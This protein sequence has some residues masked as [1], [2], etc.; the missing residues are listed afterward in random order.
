MYEYVTD[1]NLNRFEQKEEKLGKI[2]FYD[3]ANIPINDSYNEKEGGNKFLELFLCIIT[4]I[5]CWLQLL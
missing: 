5:V 2:I 1:P 3:G 4:W